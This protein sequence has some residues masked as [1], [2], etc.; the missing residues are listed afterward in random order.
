MWYTEVNK[1]S[2]KND[3]DYADQDLGLKTFS[4][5]L[6]SLLVLTH[7]VFHFHLSSP[8]TLC[9]LTFIFTL[10]NDI[11]QELV[12]DFHTSS[13]KVEPFQVQAAVLTTKL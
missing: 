5:C 7:N 11:E 8:C 9:A 10:L 3:A 6:F 12:S 1:K 13:T 4:E 2:I